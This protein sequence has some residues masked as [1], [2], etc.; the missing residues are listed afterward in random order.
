MSRKFVITGAGLVLLGMVVAGIIGQGKA[1]PPQSLAGGPET[2]MNRPA[3]E[4]YRLMK[5]RFSV[6][7][8]SDQLQAPRLLRLLR[9]ASGLSESAV[10]GAFLQRVGRFA[11]PVWLMI[12]RNQV[13]IAQ[14]ELEGAYCEKPEHVY[15][16]GIAVATFQASKDEELTD[17]AI[18]GIAP[19]GKRFVTFLIGNERQR[20][21][22]HRNFY[23]AAAPVPI[24]VVGFR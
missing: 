11:G 20:Q 4:T 2:G 18:S 15:R 10:Q 3:K 17:F 6:L 8:R 14:Q 12:A 7:G 24:K 13:C 21:P 19:D 5:R 16:R 23:A 1:P 22:I 9:Q